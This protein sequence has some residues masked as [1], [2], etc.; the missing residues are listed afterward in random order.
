MW[1]GGWPSGWLRRFHDWIGRDSG[2]AVDEWTDVGGFASSSY[3]YLP[4]HGPRRW[5][6][7][8][9]AACFYRHGYSRL[10]PVF[11]RPSDLGYLDEFR[12]S[13]KTER[14]FSAKHSS[15]MLGN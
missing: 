11:R 3:C 12:R 5:S 15:H 1:V 10:A 14:W 9:C 4:L 6:T 8:R 7:G 13:R 2:G